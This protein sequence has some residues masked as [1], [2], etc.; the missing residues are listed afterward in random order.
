MSSAQF[1][2]DEKRQIQAY[3]GDS[4]RYAVKN[5]DASKGKLQVRTTPEGSLWLWAYNQKRGVGKNFNTPAPA[6]PEQK[7]WEAW[8]ESKVQYDRYVAQLA[9]DK[10]NGTSLAKAA[11]APGPMPESLRLLVGDAPLFANAIQPKVHS[12]RFDDGFAVDLED[13]PSMAPRFAYY[14]FA[15]GVRHFGT[16]LKK[17]EPDNLRE[18]F[19]AA[20]IPVSEQRVF[21]AVSLLEGGFESVNTYD[22]GYVSVGFI[23]FACLGKGSGSLGT[24]LLQMKNQ[25]PANFQQDFRRFGLDVVADGSLTA[26]NLATGETVTGY[27]AARTIISD[28]R[29]AA[30]FHRAGALSTPFRVAQLKVAKNQYFPGDD[31]ITVEVDGENV[32]V[33]ISD[34]VK[35]EAG[36]ATLMDRKVNTGKLGNIAYVASQV[37]TTYGLKEANELAN[38]E[39]DIIRQMKFRK[40]YLNEDGISQPIKRVASRTSKSK[41]TKSGKQKATK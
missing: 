36:M 25:S 11:A 7:D 33:R 19:A 41:K 13:N 8:I 14:R 30:V 39:Y 4:S 34:F 40:D 16:P 12:V 26:L 38:Y 32:Q 37:A 21:K 3:W 23:Q 27:D 29:Y 9:A 28:K 2:D 10:E 5:A 6:M 20:G 31:V 22:T 17:L 35:S 24:V 1:T 15:E 18:L